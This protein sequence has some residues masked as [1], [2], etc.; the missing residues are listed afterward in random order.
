MGELES[1]RLASPRT[2]RP[3]STL[4]WPTPLVSSSSSSP[5]TRWTPPSLHTARPG[6]RRSRKKSPTSSRR[7]ATTRCC[8]L[9]PHLR[10][11]RRQHDQHLYQHVLVQGM[12]G[13]ASGTTL[14]EALDAV[15]PPTRP[16]DKPLRLPL[17]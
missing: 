12:E 1:S 8:P 9:R 7:S 13:N 16:T 6:S 14:L 3:E 2:V 15:I 4:S 5:V 17:Q 10:M 11:A